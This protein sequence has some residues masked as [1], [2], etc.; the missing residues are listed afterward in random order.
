MKK[1]ALIL[2]LLLA[3]VTLIPA[4][5]QTYNTYWKNLKTAEQKSLPQTAL[6]ISKSIFTKRKPRRILHRCSRRLFG[7]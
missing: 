3:C 2:T 6:S 4:S 1:N 7:E 5:A